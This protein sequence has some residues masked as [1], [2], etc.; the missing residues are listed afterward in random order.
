[1]L[2]IGICI[3]KS[4]LASTVEQ[5]LL[6]LK[7][8]Q[9]LDINIDVYFCAEYF[10]KNMLIS[11]PYDIIYFEIKSGCEKKKDLYICQKVHLTTFSHI[12]IVSEK[13]LLAKEIIDIEPTALLI[14]PF[15][16][17]EF[18][19]SFLKAYN[20]I[21]LNK[22]FFEFKFNKVIYNIPLNNIVYFES[23]QRKVII[24]TNDTKFSFYCKLDEIE[25]QLKQSK[26]R[27]LRIHQS[28][29]VNFDYIKTIYCSKVILINGEILQISAEK[30]KL[31]HSKF[32][33]T[34]TDNFGHNFNIYS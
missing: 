20:K 16:S 11:P 12:I 5:K 3:S 21:K 4:I 27:F 18:Y 22:V 6:N 24:V 25:K 13:E 14:P 8:D 32:E 31:L 2:N 28:F 9:R 34:N 29:L 1:M 33:S 7:N 19:S 15:E 30:L 17:N 10:I 26:Q 23:Q